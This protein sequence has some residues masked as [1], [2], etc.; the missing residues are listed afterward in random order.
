[1]S[2][3]V[4]FRN[5]LR[6]HDNP[7]LQAACQ[8][9]NPVE[10]VFIITRKQ[11][12]AHDMAP[13]RER[14]LADCVGALRADLA[15]KRIPLHLVDA[16][17]F[18]NTPRVLQGL[19]QR[20]GATELFFN[21]EYEW[22]EQQR[23]Q[24]VTT[25]LASAGVTVRR[26]HDQCL[27]PPGGVRTLQGAYFKVYS[28]FRRACVKAL[29]DRDLT[30]LPAPRARREA[31]GEA[32]TAAWLPPSTPHQSLWKGGEDEALKRL[33]AFV[34]QRID[35]YKS[36]RDFPAEAGTSALSPYL[37]VG[38]VSVRQCLHAARLAGDG[39][40]EPSQP[41]IACWINELLWREFYR[42]LMVGFPHICRH[43]AFNR[44]TD[45]IPWRGTSALFDSWTN[46]KTGYPI[47]DAAMAQLR[48]TGWMHNRLRMVTAMFL[49]KHLFTDWRLG[50]RFFMQHLVDGDLASN[51]GGWQWSASTG[52]DAAPYFR[53][54][55]PKL[56]SE[57]FDQDGLFIR[58]WIPELRDV[59]ARE[60]HAPY[61]LL[62][63]A[64]G[65][66]LPIVEHRTAT[67]DVKRHFGQ[68]AALREHHDVS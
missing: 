22:N 9:G 56:Q 29:Q 41:G 14:F 67:D 49:T 2:A 48:A 59:D 38:A 33:T 40:L 5:D 45:A 8:S 36:T 31:S 25:L 17:D 12:V 13:V 44:E 53:V 30:P 63:R 55:N 18:L 24:T 3:L 10:A 28:P 23:D 58:Q 51:N 65:Y 39:T 42:H 32:E 37:A 27:I 50:E 57:R 20:R 64:I 19:I 54:F 16:G 43:K 15:A 60:V 4:W 7:A 11:W 1:M 47:V 26:F 6:V 68:L 61:P 62:A 21:D 34:Q 66:P 46:S 35:A 52:A